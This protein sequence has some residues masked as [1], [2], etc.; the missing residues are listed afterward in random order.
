MSDLEAR[1]EVLERQM[2]QQRRL[3]RNL[4]CWVDTHASPLIKRVWWA[5]RGFRFI[6][7]GRW[8]GAGHT[9]GWPPPDRH[10]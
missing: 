4:Y 9:H 2:R 10:K 7:L 5:F 8:Y 3:T 1:V 6:R